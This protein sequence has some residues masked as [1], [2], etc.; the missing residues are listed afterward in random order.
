[1]NHMYRKTFN[2]YVLDYTLDFAKL[3][4][5]ISKTLYINNKSKLVLKTN[6]KPSAISFES[7]YYLG[8]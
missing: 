8:I 4:T 1:M 3:F 7:F 5:H 6:P 2:M